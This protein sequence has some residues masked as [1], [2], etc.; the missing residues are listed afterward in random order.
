MYKINAKD[1]LIDLL[2]K[3]QKRVEFLIF[4]N[5]ECKT[6]LKKKG[7]N[8]D[9]VETNLLKKFELVYF[10]YKEIEKEEEGKIKENEKKLTYVAKFFDEKG[11]INNDGVMNLI[12]KA[13]EE[14]ILLLKNI[15][16][17]PNIVINYF[18][19]L[20]EIQKCFIN[21]FI[22]QLKENILLQEIY[23]KGIKDKEVE[24]LDFEEKMI[25]KTK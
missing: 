23:Y 5:E 1:L 14:Y 18:D 2:Y 17:F 7:D 6:I 21:Q 8:N 10:Q 20:N 3:I 9:E 12:M 24:R 15:I 19:F 11:E 13:F 4:I 16:K 22:Q 25:Y